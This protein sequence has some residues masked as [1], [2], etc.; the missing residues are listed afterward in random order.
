MDF[1][2]DPGHAYTGDH[3]RISSS[4]DRVRAFTRFAAVL[5]DGGIR[6]DMPAILL[7]GPS[8]TDIP[9]PRPFAQTASQLLMPEAYA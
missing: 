9:I 8:G 3:E 2:I 6:R 7:Q 4:E 5:R 1:V